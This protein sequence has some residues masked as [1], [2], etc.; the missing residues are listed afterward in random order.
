M[1]LFPP[2]IIWRFACWLWTFFVLLNAAAVSAWHIGG[3]VRWWRGDTTIKMFKS[4]IH[5]MMMGRGGDN[6]GREWGWMTHINIQ[7]STREIIPKMNYCLEQSIGSLSHQ[8]SSRQHKMGI[9]CRMEGFFSFFAL[10]KHQTRDFRDAP[11]YQFHPCAVLL[12]C[13]FSIWMSDSFSESRQSGKFISRNSHLDLLFSSLFNQAEKWSN[14]CLCHAEKRKFKPP[15]VYM[16]KSLIFHF[17]IQFSTK[18]D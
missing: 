1:L 10:F 17:G 7:R 18:Y 2:A 14:T 12:D 3:V 13:V 6:C 8:L 15:S 11:K 5:W 16:A 4:S 9:V